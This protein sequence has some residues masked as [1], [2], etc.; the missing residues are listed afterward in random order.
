LKTANQLVKEIAS[1]VQSPPGVTIVLTEEPG[2]QPNWVAA[3]AI[4]DS[5]KFSET[6]AK[7]RKT[8]PLVDWDEVDKGANEL[9]RVVKFP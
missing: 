8:D 6:V 4:M 1:A 3:A 5:D 9:R 2:A 7:F